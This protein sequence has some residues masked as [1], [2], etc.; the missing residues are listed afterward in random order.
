MKKFSLRLIKPF[1]MTD[2]RN[3]D[4]YFHWLLHDMQEKD[5]IDHLLS[6]NWERAG[7]VSELIWMLFL[8]W[9]N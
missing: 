4:T 6:L 8:T 1:T 5:Q 9:S 7:R 3:V 2:Y